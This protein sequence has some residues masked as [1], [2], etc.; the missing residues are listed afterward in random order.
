MVCQKCG[1]V[2]APRDDCLGLLVPKD[3][4]GA[5]MATLLLARPVGEKR[6]RGPHEFPSYL[7]SE[8]ES[9]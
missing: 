5:V 4:A 6:R 8:G 2:T 9:R 7:E 3:R 1:L